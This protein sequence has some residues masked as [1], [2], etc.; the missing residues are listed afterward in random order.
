[1]QQTVRVFLNGRNAQKIEVKS[2]K[3]PTQ[4]QN[5]SSTSR[6]CPQRNQNTINGKWWFVNPFIFQN[7]YFTD[8]IPKNTDKT[9]GFGYPR[10]LNELNY[11]MQNFLTLPRS[12][13]RD[14]E[15]TRAYIEKDITRVFK[16]GEI[17]FS[18]LSRNMTTSLL[19]V[20]LPPDR[21]PQSCLWPRCPLWEGG[22]KGSLQGGSVP[23]GHSQTCPA[24]TG[25]FTA[26]D[27]G[28]AGAGLAEPPNPSHPDIWDC[29]CR[30][31]RQVGH[32]C[33]SLGEI[34]WDP[35]NVDKPQQNAEVLWP[36]LQ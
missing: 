8:N 25:T 22:E 9:V 1:M 29:S 13:T 17:Q 12:R 21:T 6:L 18:N 15:Q 36:H 28:R 23:G 14:K 11:E 7:L 10:Q 20:A 5:F 32:N 35:K 27:I 19:T 33:P 2:G 24:V 30:A 31:W 3:E 34:S 26:A 4:T 16:G